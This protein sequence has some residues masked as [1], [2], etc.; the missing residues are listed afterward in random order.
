MRF[1]NVAVTV[2]SS[3]GCRKVAVRPQ[4]GDLTWAEGDYPTPLGPIHIRV[5]KTESGLKTDVRA[6]EGVEIVR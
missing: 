2:T 5:E 4:L 3:P 6:P 1:S